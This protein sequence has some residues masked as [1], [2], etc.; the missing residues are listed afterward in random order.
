M[1]KNPEDH[2]G[3]FTRDDA[4]ELVR[5]ARIAA[6][7]PKDDEV[8]EKLNRFMRAALSS[9]EELDR[10]VLELNRRFAS[11]VIVTL[12]PGWGTRSEEE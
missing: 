2:D 10:L 8:A 7:D 6:N 12:K 5:R 3:P 4:R 11:R 1:T 9:D